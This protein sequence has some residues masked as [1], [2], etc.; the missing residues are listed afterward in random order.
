MAALPCRR[1]PCISISLFNCQS[2]NA[3]LPTLIGVCL[4]W[5][6]NTACISF[7]LLNRFC[8]LLFALGRDLAWI[9]LLKTKPLQLEWLSAVCGEAIQS[10]GMD[11]AA[12]RQD[13]ALPLY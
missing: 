4:R 2:L 6:I 7:P 10:G 8:F 5:S 13:D 1:L 3:L 9:D 11:A 12:G